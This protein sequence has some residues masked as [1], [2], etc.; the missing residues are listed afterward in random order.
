M[1]AEGQRRPLGILRA[2]A[3][4]EEGI[5]VGAGVM[6]VAPALRPGGAV[7]VEGWKGEVQAVRPGWWPDEWGREE[8]EGET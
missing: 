4:L 5:H 7:A 8:G 2:C 3:T 1:R 6:R